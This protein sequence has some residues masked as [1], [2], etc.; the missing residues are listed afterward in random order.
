MHEQAKVPDCDN[1]EAWAE[2]P[3]HY[4]ESDICPSCPHS[5]DIEHPLTVKLLRY[6][7]IIAGG[8]P[9]G[10]HELTNEEWVMLGSINAAYEAMAMEDLK[11]KRK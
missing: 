9:V 2:N 3:A 1:C 11:A 7:A 6:R 10:R 8:C 4:V 5:R